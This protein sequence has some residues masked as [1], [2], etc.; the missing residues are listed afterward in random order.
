MS[1]T[2]VVSIDAIRSLAGGSITGTYAAVGGSLTEQVRLIC[3]TNNTDGDVFF[4]DDGVNNK[5]FVAKSS[6]KLFDL[7]TNRQNRD[8]IWCFPIGTQ[9]YVKQSSATSTG[10]VYIEC[11]WGQ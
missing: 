7:T 6:F 5:I 2:Q 9:F 10:S 3:F 11:L 4:S 1:N 8:Q